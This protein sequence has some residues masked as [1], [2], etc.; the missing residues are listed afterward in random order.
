MSYPNYAPSGSGPMYKAM[1]DRTLTS[2]LGL[3]VTGG[4]SSKGK[5]GWFFD[6]GFRVS[7]NVPKRTSFESPTPIA[8]YGRQSPIPS[9]SQQMQERRMK[10][11]SVNVGGSYLGGQG[12]PMRPTA[13]RMPAPSVQ[14]P[15][16]SSRSYERMPATMRGIQAPSYSSSYIPTRQSFVQA[17]TPPDLAA[18]LRDSVRLSPAQLYL[19]Q[20]RGGQGSFLDNLVSL[21][22]YQPMPVSVGPDWLNTQGVYI[23]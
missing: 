19:S 22:E 8:M 6:T 11:G 23:R 16:F 4:G 12:T 9:I 14:M 10:Y 18:S 13:Q 21:L 1:R 3:P 17:A 7:S 2:R 5:P 20:V 15:K